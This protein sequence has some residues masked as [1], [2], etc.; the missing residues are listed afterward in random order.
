MSW[1]WT[2]LVGYL[3]V[4]TA[5]KLGKNPIY[6]RAERNQNSMPWPLDDCRGRDL[7]YKVEDKNNSNYNRAMM[8]RFRR[9]IDDLALKEIPLHGRKFTWSNQHE[10]STLVKLDRV[11][12]TVEWEDLFHNT[13]LQSAASYDSDHCPLLLGLKDNKPGKRRFH[14]EAFWPKVEGFHEAVEEAWHSVQPGPCLLLDI[15]S[16]IQSN[17][18][19]TPSVEWQE[20]G[21]CWVTAR[22]GERKSASAQRV[23]IAQDGRT[24]SQDET[25]LK[26]ML[27]KKSLLLA[28]LKQTIARLRSRINWLKEGDANTSFFQLHAWHRKRKNFIGKIVSDTQVCTSHDDKTK[29]VDE[30]YDNLVGKA[31]IREHTIDLEELE[32]REHTKAE[33]YWHALGVPVHDLAELDSPIVEKEVW[34]TIKQLPSDK[35]PGP[36]GSQV[37]SIKLAGP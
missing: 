32:F 13:L 37:V 8:G 19:R 5:R 30:F 10:S 7:I 29:I 9:L 15:A 31:E 22:F 18:R 14:F 21:T 6:A 17:G 25:V 4:W 27:K 36:D 20:G 23:E 26:G 35:A 33:F 34:E 28:S 1:W 24:L 2:S 3:G 16:E 12:C 11:L